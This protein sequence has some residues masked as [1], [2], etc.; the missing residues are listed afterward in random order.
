MFSGF[1]GVLPP[2][3]GY[4]FGILAVSSFIMGHLSGFQSGLQ[5]TLLPTLN[6]RGG[7]FGKFGSEEDNAQ[8]DIPFSEVADSLEGPAADDLREMGGNINI[9]LTTMDFALNLTGKG[10][11]WFARAA[12][13][14]R[15]DGAEAIRR[16]AEEMAV[17]QMNWARQKQSSNVIASRL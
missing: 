8:W 4:M 12:A 14:C 11:E 1:F 6:K 2:H 3:D 15:L 7:V 17:N 5:F 9:S 10:E 16:P 13:S